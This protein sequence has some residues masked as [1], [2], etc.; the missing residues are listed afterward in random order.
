MNA[1]IVLIAIGSAGVLPVVVWL[2]S[3]LALDSDASM[4]LFG[5]AA[6]VATAIQ[7]LLVILCAP[8]FEPARNV[9]VSIA[10]G[11]LLLCPT[12][13]LLALAA[14]AGAADGLTVL[15]TQSALI[16]SA[17]ALALASE[18]LCMLTRPAMRGLAYALVQCLSL[19]IV[20]WWHSG[21]TP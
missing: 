13:P 5:D 1:R 19:G 6:R 2:L 21:V 17:T 18:W 8:Y 3:A 11:T 9:P 7:V 10:R 20:G 15:L 4:Y 14:T 12:W 16:G